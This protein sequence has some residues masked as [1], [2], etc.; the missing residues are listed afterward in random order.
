M[1]GLV[2][3]NASNLTFQPLPLPELFGSQIGPTWAS[4]VEHCRRPSLTHRIRHT[5][6]TEIWLVRVVKHQF[7][8]ELVRRTEIWPVEEVDNWF[9]S[10]PV[11]EAEI[12]LVPVVEDNEFAWEV[13]CGNPVHDCW[14]G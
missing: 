13:V 12:W 1:F 4:V 10:G 8:L 9:A 3:E 14:V 7:A 11:W 6:G 5:A 2:W